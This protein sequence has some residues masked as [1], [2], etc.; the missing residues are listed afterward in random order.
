MFWVGQGF[1]YLLTLW[2]GACAGG[3]VSLGFGCFTVSPVLG[4]FVFVF[5]GFSPFEVVLLRYFL[6]SGF[7]LWVCVFCFEFVFGI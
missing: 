3:L 2:V 5:C 6:T 4:W 1:C 7:N